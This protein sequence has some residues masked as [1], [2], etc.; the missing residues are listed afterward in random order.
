[1]EAVTGVWRKV[2]AE[3]TLIGEVQMERISASLLP[4]LQNVDLRVGGPGSLATLIL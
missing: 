1:M 4:Y 2:K 3:R